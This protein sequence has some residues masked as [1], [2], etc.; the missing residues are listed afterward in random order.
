MKETEQWHYNILTSN[1]AEDYRQ[2]EKARVSEYNAGRCEQKNPL[3]QLEPL[4][5]QQPPQQVLTRIRKRL[6]S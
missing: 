5:K 2:R 1:K 6:K 3:L 4:Q